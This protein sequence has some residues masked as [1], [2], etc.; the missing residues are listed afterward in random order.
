MKKDIYSQLYDSNLTIN[1]K[2]QVITDSYI[3]K[4]KKGETDLLLFKQ[5][6]IVSLGYYYLTLE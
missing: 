3:D 5:N 1:N 6:V 4:F 2:F